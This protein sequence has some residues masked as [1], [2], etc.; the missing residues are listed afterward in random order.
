MDEME[1]RKMIVEGLAWQIS[2][3]GRLLPETDD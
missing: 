1:K 2:T 3:F